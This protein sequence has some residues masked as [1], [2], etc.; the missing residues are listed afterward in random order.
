MGMEGR[1]GFELN[2]QTQG[3]G[4]TAHS[5]P[6]GAPG[7]AGRGGFATGRAAVR[8][9]CP[10]QVGEEKGMNGDTWKNKTVSLNRIG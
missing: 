7:A 3:W 1:L 4:E 5:F 10:G 9:T 8:R 2:T 6:I